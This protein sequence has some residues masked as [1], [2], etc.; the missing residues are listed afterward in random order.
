M[1][2][3]IDHALPFLLAH[4]GFQ[5]QILQTKENLNKIGVEVDFL[6]WWD[7]KQQGNIIHYFGGA[8]ST[9]VDYCHRKGLKFILSDL[10]TGLGSRARWKIVAHRIL[11]EIAQCSM[12]RLVLGKLGWD[13]YPRVDAA[14]AL[15][16][17]EKHLMVDVFGAPR[18]RVHVIPN[19]VEDVFFDSPVKDRGKWL[20]CAATVTQRKR[21]LELARAAVIA[22]TPLWVIGRP[23]DE[24][25][26]YYRSFLSVVR[27]HSEIV[28]YEGGIDDRCRLAEIYRIARGFVLAS[29]METL[30]LSA[31]E[32][33]ASHCPLLL[34]KLPWAT[35]SFG[36]K[37]SYC[38]NSSDPRILADALRNF[39]DAEFH[40]K[41]KF[42]PLRWREVAE[43]VS[44]V[45]E[46]VLRE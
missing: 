20:L 21:V 12:P 29:A 25:D 27:D 30:S 41:S 17:W 46:M 2:V 10:R 38:P 39:Y 37:V 42:V 4:G 3:L 6:R 35:S 7:D 1:K 22:K 5:T 9:Y 32:A 43:Q 24:S 33:A 18:E 45:Y 19:G 44:R 28:R 23:Y 31:L 11:V 13:V 34:T 26:P 40:G 36:E 14:I 16:S 15:T 8:N